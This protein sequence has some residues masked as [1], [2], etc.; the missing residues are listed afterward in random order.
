MTL[1]SFLAILAGV[2]FLGLGIRICRAMLREERWLPVAIADGK[3]IF[4]E[5]TFTGPAHF[6]IVARVDR[7]YASGRQIHLVELKAR[8]DIRLH[9]TDIIEMSAQRV[10][11]QASTGMDVSLTGFV[12]IEHPENHRRVVRATNLLSDE[13]IAGLEVR[14][15]AILNGI[16][17]PREAFSKTRCLRCEYRSECKGGEGF[18]MYFFIRSSSEAGIGWNAPGR[19]TQL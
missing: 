11:V 6:P 18:K 2:F 13:Q 4:S 12:M 1:L 14:R 5:Q 8:R 17:T 15:R 16:E 9:E 19:I 3:L 10:A 7:A